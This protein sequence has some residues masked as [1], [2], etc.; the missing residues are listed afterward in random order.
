M[1]SFS[2]GSVVLIS[3]L[4]IVGLSLQSCTFKSKSEPANTLHLVA[5]EKIKGLDPIYSD[6]LYSSIQSSQAY[7]T[8]LGYHYL[9]RP[10]TLTPNLAE[11]L[12]EVSADR[13]TYT[14]HLKKGVLF[15]DDPCFKET[16]GKGREMTADDVVYSV[17]RLADPKLAS[18]GWWIFDG[19]IAGLN[20]WRDFVLKSTTADYSQAI[21][22]IKALD[23][24]TV[25]FKLI[26]PSSL[27]LYAMAMQ[28]T[29]VVPHEAI[30]HY[31]KEFINH[32]VG[33]G[34]F[35]L[36]EFNPNSKIVWLKNPTYRKEM[37]PS[38]GAP[39]DREGGLLIDAGKALPLADKMVITVFVERQPMWLTFLSGKLDTSA[40]PKDN[41]S[42]AITPGKDLNPDLKAKGIRLVKSPGL[43]ITHHSFNMA[44]P[45]LGKNKLLRQAISLAF[46]EATFIDLF[47]NGRAI[48]AQGP[49]PPGI[50]GYDP[51]FKNPYRQFNLL[52]AKELLEK[53][54][55]PGG[56]GLPTLEYGSLADSVGRQQ[57]EFTQKM[58]A[59]IGV[60]IRV[61]SYSWPQFQEAIKNKRIQMWAQ[62]WSADYP[63]AENF[64]QL[65]YSRN[66]SPGPNDANYSNQDYDR[67]YE[68]ALTLPS[69]PERTAIYKKMV[70]MVVEDCPWIFGSHRI[71]YG[72]VQPWLK[73]YKPND[74][75]HTRYKYYRIET[76]LKK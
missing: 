52:K 67:L 76:T 4:Q 47:Y 22:G 20:S 71:G 25:Q 23:R 18:P 35:R 10:Y 15:Q 49:I 55:Y 64:L 46:D 26:Q 51:D 33:T 59:A 14:F 40:I 69:G 27:F 54:G 8:L 68:K 63:D 32:A 65:F 19:K 11:T 43:D 57:A 58:L 6:D 28:F 62:A 61:N 1:G 7:E 44:D 60:N 13:L 66:A 2:K 53:A 41:F 74:F 5:E 56:K 12:P 70:D 39:G 72:L 17:K 42:A 24:Y 73:N 21:E 36:D 50:E 37:Y 48:P 29:A 3:L 34:P 38:E 31:G 45:L 16:H 75:D 30:E 9:K